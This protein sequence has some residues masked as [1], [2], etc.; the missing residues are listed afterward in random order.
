MTVLGETVV[1]HHPGQPTKDPDRGSRVAVP[2][3]DETITGVAVAPGDT[4]ENHDRQSTV[5]VEF[6]L[7][8]TRIVTIEPDAQITVRG[9]RREVEGE[10]KAWRNPDTFEEGTEVAVR[11]SS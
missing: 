2:G 7:Y 8:F 4:R 1:I 6:T 3:E 10:A 11:R 5:A 9:H